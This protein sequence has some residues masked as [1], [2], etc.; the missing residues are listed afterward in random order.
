MK[1]IGIYPGSFNPFHA[2][3]KDILSKAL[4]VFDQVIVVSIKN[5]EKESDQSLSRICEG[6][7]KK[8][9]STM[10]QSEIS[11]IT[12]VEW[13]DDVLYSAVKRVISEFGSNHK[14]AIIRGLRNGHDLQY[15]MNNQYWN[16]DTGLYYPFVYFI[17]DRALAHVSSSSIRSVEKLNLQHP[18]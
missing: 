2:G 15:E 12:L 10:D 1:K 8:I 13:T 3:H 7:N 14:Y 17:T 5:P 16:E 18:Y 6:I 11:N 9:M 4:E